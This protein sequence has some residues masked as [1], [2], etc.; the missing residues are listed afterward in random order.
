MNCCIILFLC[1]GL[2]PLKSFRT[3]LPWFRSI[4]VL[5]TN[6]PFHIKDVFLVRFKLFRI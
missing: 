5:F 2:P 3:M 6:M 4:G 1:R